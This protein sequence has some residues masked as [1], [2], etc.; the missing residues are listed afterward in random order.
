M[1]GG[2]TKA[3]SITLVS[4]RAVRIAALVAVVAVLALPG[5]ALAHPAQYHQT[6]NSTQQQD[7]GGGSTTSP[8]IIAVVVVSVV[9]LAGALYAV[10]RAQRI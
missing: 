5:A 10:K 9:A 4:S 6:P 2:G 8:V 3:P 1:R 7:D